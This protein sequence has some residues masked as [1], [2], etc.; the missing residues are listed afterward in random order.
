MVGFSTYAAPRAFKFDNKTYDA[1]SD[2]VTISDVGYFEPVGVSGYQWLLAV[3]KTTNSN[4]STTFRF[5]G[6]LKGGLDWFSWDANDDSTVV[7]GD[8]TISRWIA[9]AALGDSFKIQFLSQAGGTD[10]TPTA[11]IRFANP[12]PVKK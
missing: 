7:I 5:L 3:I 4:T 10:A 12:M 1:T 11:Q 2:T 6:K 9:C 8:T